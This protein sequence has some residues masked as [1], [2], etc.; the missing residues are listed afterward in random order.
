MLRQSVRYSSLRANCV[1]VLD[2]GFLCSPLQK[3]SLMLT[4]DNQTTASVFSL[5]TWKA[6]QAQWERREIVS[7]CPYVCLLPSGPAPYGTEGLAPK[8]LSK[9]FH[10][11]LISSL[12]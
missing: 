4:L 8:Q 1:S 11:L 9:M 12:N 3:Y 7:Q 6:D 5:S 2:S 10:G